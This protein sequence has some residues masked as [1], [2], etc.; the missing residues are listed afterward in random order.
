MPD[1]SKEEQSPV[2][3]IL[4]ACSGM[5]Y[6]Q[7]EIAMNRAAQ[8]FSAELETLK[9]AAVIGNVPRGTVVDG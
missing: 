8:I 4:K 7:A 2:D 1:L 6:G 3:A 9:R 5:T